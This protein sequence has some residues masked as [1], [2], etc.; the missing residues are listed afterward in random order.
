MI[1]QPNSPHVVIARAHQPRPAQTNSTSPLSPSR[2]RAQI[3]GPRGPRAAGRHRKVPGHVEAAGGPGAEQ[4]RAAAGA[5]QGAARPG[6]GAGQAGLGC[7][8]RQ[9]GP[10][11]RCAARGLL[12]SRRAADALTA[13][14]AA[15]AQAR[16]LPP[17]RTRT[18]GASAR[19]ACT[20]AT[21]PLSGCWPPSTA[22][23]RS[24]CT[25]GCG[26]PG[27]PWGSRAPRACPKPPPRAAAR[28]AT[29]E[30]H[31]MLLLFAS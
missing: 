6:G 23:R 14:R 30:Q 31:C 10:G 27:A 25:P 5:P 18:C 7:E 16:A 20:R 3:R 28:W 9:Q 1:H 22:S 17:R 4:P 21:P 15:A 29:R 19:A 11:R 13:S 12:A 2:S 24:R 8:R 26:P